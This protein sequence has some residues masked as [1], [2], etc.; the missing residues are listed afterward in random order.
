MINEKS[1]VKIK[2][3]ASRLSLDEKIA[4]C[5]AWET[6][7]MS[8]TPV[9]GVLLSNIAESKNSPVL[10]FVWMFVYGCGLGFL[11]MLVGTFAGLLIALPKSGPWLKW[12]HQL[13]GW[14]LII[15]ACYLFFVG[16]MRA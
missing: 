9:L 6:S 12:L 7:R 5:K 15:F 3:Q 8:K 16:G 13:F 2:P 1:D 11:Y 10:G 4:L 14:L